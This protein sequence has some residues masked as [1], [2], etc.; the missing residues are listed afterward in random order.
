MAASLFLLLS[1]ILAFAGGGSPWVVAATVVSAAITGTRLP[2]LDTPLKLGHRSA[3]LHGVVPMLVALLDAR[4]W[5]VA[6]GLGFGIGLHLAAD[7]FPG[8]MRGFATIK[9]PL[10]GSIGAGLS[11]LW[12]AVNAAANLIGAIWILPWIADGDGL[13]ATLAGIGLVG[14]L[15]LLSA[16]GGWAALVLLGAIGWWWLR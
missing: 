2:D 5:G 12:I 3:L 4:T 7:L 1:V 14:V 16:K 8:R 9:L 13:S 10:V 6:A 11:Y 15:Y